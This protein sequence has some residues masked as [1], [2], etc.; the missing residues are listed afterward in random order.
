MVKTHVKNNDLMASQ[1]AKVLVDTYAEA[2]VP[3]IYPSNVQ[4]VSKDLQN[5]DKNIYTVSTKN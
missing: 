5:G 4:T 2:M 1:A 3:A